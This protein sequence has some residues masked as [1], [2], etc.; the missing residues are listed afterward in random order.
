[1]KCARLLTN[2][3]TSSFAEADGPIRNIYR[4]LLAKPDK[5]FKSRGRRDAVLS[6]QIKGPK[7]AILFGICSSVV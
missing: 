3:A 7:F 2:S 1:M 4:V 5:C 6:L